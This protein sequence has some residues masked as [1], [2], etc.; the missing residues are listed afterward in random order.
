MA[1]T[2][3]RALALSAAMFFLA[4]AVT[5]AQAPDPL[6]YWE[7]SIILSPAEDELDVIAEFSRDAKGA[8]QGRLWFPTHPVGPFDMETSSLHGAHLSFDVRDKDGVVSAFEGEIAANGRALAGTFREKLQ[9]YPFALERRAAPP[10]VEV[11]IQD[12]ADDASELKAEINRESGHVRLLLVLSPISLSAKVALKLVERYVLEAMPDP[13][14]RVYVVWEVPDV[15]GAESL[16]AKR[17]KP[18]ASDPRVVEFWSRSGAA[19]KALRSAPT[20]VNPEKPEDDEAFNRC[21]LFSGEKTWGQSPPAPDRVWKS[22]RLASK[23]Q[24]PKPRRFDAVEVA[25][26][27]RALLAGKNAS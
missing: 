3:T 7:G 22:A 14:L 1:L 21:L 8:L 5:A 18:L 26:A 13:A 2:A 9:S 15:P 17:F 25:S 11:A 6:G 16:T 10:P 19:T 12:L 27:V 24:L 4:A 20:A 23:P